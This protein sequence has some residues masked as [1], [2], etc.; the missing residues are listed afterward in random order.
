MKSHTQEFCLVD[1]PESLKPKHDGYDD[2]PVPGKGNYSST[3]G[4]ASPDGVPSHVMPPTKQDKNTRPPPDGFPADLPAPET[5]SSTQFKKAEVLF[6]IVGEYIASC[7]FS[8]NW[9]LRD[10]GILRVIETIDSNFESSVGDR[11]AFMILCKVASEALEDRVPSVFHQ[12]A[13]LAQKLVEEF[14]NR[15]SIRD[16]QHATTE[17]VPLL[18]QKTGDNNARVRDSAQTLILFLAERKDAL[19]RSM[20]P[21]FLKFPKKSTAW[22]P[23]LGKLELIR[24]LVPIFGVG[25][26]ES[27]FELASLMEFVGRSFN[28]PNGEVRSTAISVTLEIFEIVGAVV[29]KF[30]PRGM[31]PKI[32]A[33]LDAGMARKSA[34]SKNMRS[35]TTRPTKEEPNPDVHFTNPDYAEGL[36][37]QL[38]SSSSPRNIRHDYCCV[39]VTIL[40]VLKWLSVHQTRRTCQMTQL[41]TKLK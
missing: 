18:V 4:S 17:F 32:M 24:K 39:Q 11:D 38:L 31:N 34:E 20:I 37:P 19:N 5:L 22:R 1:S 15:L 40:S 14:S 23:V 6:P 9:Q 27:A 26:H 21:V 12:A 8:R 30:L 33:Q 35:S 3:T 7:I 13:R 25:K 28:S 10:A 29:Q 41:S 2:R 16:I 36:S